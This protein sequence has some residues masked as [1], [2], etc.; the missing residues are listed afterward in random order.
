MDLLSM[1]IQ[2]YEFVFIIPN[3]WAGDL[4][5]VCDVIFTDFLL[6]V[7]NSTTRLFELCFQIFDLKENIN[8]LKATRGQLLWLKSIMRQTGFKTKPLRDFQCCE[9]KNVLIL[10]K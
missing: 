7:H 9:S 8:S 6:I 1:L 10:V 2:V 4:I 5:A 3:Y